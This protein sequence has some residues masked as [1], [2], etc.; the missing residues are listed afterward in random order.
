MLQHIA[1]RWIG[2]P[3]MLHSG[4]ANIMAQA[5]GPRVFEA[6]NVRVNAPKEHASVMGLLALPMERT[7]PDYVVAPVSQS[8]AVI[9]IE[10]TLCAKGKWVG[11][12]SGSTSYEGII[13]QANLAHDDDNVR[14]VI[15]E[16]D[17]F[18]GE[19]ALAFAC[20]KALKCL[21]DRKPVI[22][23][24]TEN[25]CSAAYLLAS[26]ARA[27][28]IPETG[29]AGSIGVI[30]MHA[31][32]ADAMANDGIEVTIISAGDRKKDFNPY[33]ALPPEV[34][35]STAADVEAVRVLFANTVGQYRGKRL[36][37]KMALATEAET[38][39]GQA[40][41]DAGLA[42]VVADPYE[43]MTA[44]IQEINAGV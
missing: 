33:E 37:A 44:F 13:A 26:T 32:F 9:E 19:V 35:D 43:A 11:Q 15:L 17:S 1:H 40:A 16:I 6:Q 8:V 20:A 39:R 21:S 25:A 38:Y 14:G 12:S 36:T 41:V 31:S 42:D 28:F 10:G 22:A 24:L 7:E 23:I 34:R 3:L 2:T 18:G 29:F 4:K 5:F 30:T 27:I